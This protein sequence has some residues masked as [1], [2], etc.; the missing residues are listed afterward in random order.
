MQNFSDIDARRE[1]LGVSQRDLCARADV[2]AS[3]YSRVKSAGGDLT[4]RI[5]RK[6]TGALD[7]IARERGVLL[8]DGESVS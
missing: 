3:T 5:L 1:R 8:V 4:P 7:A 2:N 6:L